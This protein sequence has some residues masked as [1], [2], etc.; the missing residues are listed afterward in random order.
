MM[1]GGG[2]GGAGG[3]GAGGAGGFG[4]GAGGFGGNVASSDTRTPREK[5]AT[6]LEQVKEMGFN[7]EEVILKI[8]EQTNGSVQLALEV[9]FQ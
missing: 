4:A 8:L 1:G 3:F 5:Y 6:Q 2:F 7:D 9:L